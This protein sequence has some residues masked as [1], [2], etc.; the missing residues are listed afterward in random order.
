MKESV[1][2]LCVSLCMQEFLSERE[3]VCVHVCEERK[4]KCVCVYMYVV[5]VCAW[6]CVCVC[7]YMYMY[8]YI[9]L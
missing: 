5:W 7:M 9:L 1:C 2:V 4:R 3:N 8:V 6:V